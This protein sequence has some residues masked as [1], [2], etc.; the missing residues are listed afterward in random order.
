MGSANRRRISSV[1]VKRLF[2]DSSS[3]VRMSR[4]MGFDFVAMNTRILSALKRGGNFTANQLRSRFGITD[5]SGRISDLRKAGY[6]VYT[7]RKTTANGKPI[8]VY[9]LGNPTRK[10][11]AAGYLFLQNAKFAKFDKLVG[12]NLSL[13]S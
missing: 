12:Q 6:S 7:N 4:F 9:R 3:P 5:V 10:Q 1:T 8:N 13:V 2:G 11:L